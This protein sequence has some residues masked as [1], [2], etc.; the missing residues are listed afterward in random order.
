MGKH[1]PKHVELIENVNKTVIVASSWLSVLFIFM[2]Y[3]IGLSLFKA[4]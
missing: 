1:L 2:G 3:L 4:V